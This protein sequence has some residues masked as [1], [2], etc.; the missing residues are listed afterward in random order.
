MVDPP[1]DQNVKSPKVTFVLPPEISEY[2]P[3][4]LRQG[5]LRTPAT[6]LQETQTPGPQVHPSGKSAN[7]KGKGKGKKKKKKGQKG[8]KDSKGKPAT[9]APASSRKREASPGPSR[10][11]MLS[12]SP[13]RPDEGA[14]KKTKLTRAQRRNR[15]KASLKEADGGD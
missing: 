3:E 14:A 2:H 8:K 1:P 12:P 13:V 4:V 5:A 15:K 9:E 10:S 6:A 7:E 11:V